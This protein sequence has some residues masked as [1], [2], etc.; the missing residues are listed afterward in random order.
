MK[1]VRSTLEHLCKKKNSNFPL[2]GRYRKPTVVSLSSFSSSSRTQFDN[3][4]SKIW[5]INSSNGTLMLLAAMGGLSLAQYHNDV[6]F[7]NQ[8]NSNPYTTSLEAATTV[9]ND[10]IDNNN[11][12]D[13]DETTTVIN[14]SGTHSIEIPNKVYF[15]PETT[16]ELESIVS[17]CHQEHIPIRPVGSA[18]SPNAISFQPKGMISMAN[19]DRIIN[20]DK[21]NMTVT[22]EAGAR[23][24][25]VID[26]LREHN[27]TLPN[28]ASIA[29]QQMGGFV[30]IGAHGTGAKIAPVDEFVTSLKMVTPERGVIELSP[31][32]GEMFHLA[33]VGLGCL[34]IVSEITMKCIPAHN[35][36][37]HTYVVTRE[38]AKKNLKT[39]LKKHKHIRY[40]WIPYE[41]AVVVVTNDPEDENS[42][43]LIEESNH[44]QNSSLNDKAKPLKDLLKHL[45]KDSKQPYNDDNLNERGFGE[46]RDALLSFNP[47]CGKHVKIVNKAE[48]EFWKQNEGYQLKPS[49]QL[50]QFD[51]GGQV[52]YCFFIN[53]LSLLRPIKQ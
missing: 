20:I 51:C 28:L 27:L 34:G 40:M 22:V 2:I 9:L 37:E 11:N 47:L 53:S 7:S 52:R 30:Q 1:I 36:L 21:E 6:L 4:S 14:W 29:E 41:D 44:T 26:A 16:A 49:D 10:N 45:S 23:V 25:Q 18:L 48:A 24:S 35:L 13:D 31:S 39:L 38:E 12:D 15:E 5:D 3:S 43:K 46:L 33:K 50:L 8:D 32:D 19:L 17:Q 42:A